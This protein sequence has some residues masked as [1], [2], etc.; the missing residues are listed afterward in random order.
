[1][2]FCLF[3][4]AK[5]IAQFA[6]CILLDLANACCAYSQNGSDFVQI[7]LFDKK[8]LEDHCFAFRKFGNLRLQMPPVSF[9]P[10]SPAPSKEQPIDL[11]QEIETIELERI[12]MALELADGIV[13]E[14]ARLL[15]LKR[16]T[17][18]EKMR[19]Y[20]VQAVV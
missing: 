10:A 4:V 13:S 20:G 8:E 3:I 17:L 18:I 16:T 2:V 12:N 9:V 7:Q 19:K 14:A 11:R 6:E 5:A 15:T 1:M